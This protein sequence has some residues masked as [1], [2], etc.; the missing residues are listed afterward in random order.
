MKILF[1]VSH[2][3]SE[4]SGISKKIRDQVKALTNLGIDTHL[5]FLKLDKSNHFSKRM[6]NTEV[7]EE[8]K[9]ILNI[10]KYLKWRFS[11]K[12]II[13]YLLVNDI[14]N[15]YIRYTHFCNPAFLKFLHQL[16][17]RQIKIFLEIPTYPYDLE[18][19][20]TNL[21]TRFF[22][23]IEEISRKHLHKYVDFIITFSNLK[24]IFGIRTISV[25]NGVDLNNIK[26]K[27]LRIEKETLNLIAVASMD[28]WH[29]YERII[30]GMKNYYDYENAYIVNFHLVGNPNSAESQK[31]KHL[32]EKYDLGNYV[33]FHGY[34]TG[35]PLD[36]L[37]D[38]A[39]LAIGC[40]GVHRKG[41]DRIKSLKNREY[42]A[43]GIPFIYSETD[44]QFDNKE[45][46]HK[47][48]S[49]DSAIDIVSIIDFYNKVDKSPHKIR[50]FAE[51]E[52]SWETQFLKIRDEFQE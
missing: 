5:S 34:K 4:S 28:F 19:K 20:N 38:T 15:V 48:P 8:Y 46:T 25:N 26:I 36:N 51:K 9:S 21:K 41:I 31:Y 29:G 6:I 7:L 10:H 12:S 35:K 50:A 11:Y 22:K 39:N 27:S 13:E 44:D 43:R 3:L 52:L 49:N 33:R 14:K 42:C 45:F 2:G 17:K 47:A 1:I 32:V 40:L 30:E 23:K 24:Y 16:K 18:Y 37:F